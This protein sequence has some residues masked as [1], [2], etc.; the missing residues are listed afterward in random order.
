MDAAIWIPIAV[1]FLSALVGALVRRH[2][3]DS[4]LRVFQG[5]FVYVK[6]K[7]GRW[8]WGN[9]IVYSNALELEYSAGVDLNSTFEKRS[10]IFFEHELDS[11]E[12]VVRPSPKE[13]TSQ[14]YQ[15]LEEIQQLQN[16]SPRRRFQ[17]K[18]RNVF[19]ML[20]DAFAQSVSM[21][22]GA[23]K[24]KT[25]LAKIPIA[26]DKVGEVGKT[27]I[28]VIPNSYEPILEKYLGRW[29]V[30]QTPID[31][32]IH[33]QA[34]ILQE[35]TSKY[36]LVRDVEYLKEPPPQAPGIPGSGANFDVAFSRPLNAIRHVA[37]RLPGKPSSPP[38]GP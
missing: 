37:V 29:V 22:F 5:S 2:T 35:Y 19:N 23:I 7:S 28:T 15:W 34:G 27:L 21:I 36:A 33:E 3:K 12:R 9:L 17:R 26:D 10:Y 6:L 30:V 11:I 14:H 32:E 13:G 16:P 1:L 8:I 38:N 31:K 18:I 25:S 24:Q 20:R 4:C